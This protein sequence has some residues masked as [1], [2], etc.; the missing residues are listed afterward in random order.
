MMDLAAA[1]HNLTGPI[2]TAAVALMA[3]I[4]RETGV[5]E[6]TAIMMSLEDQPGHEIV[7]HHMAFRPALRR[8]QM[9]FLHESARQTD[10]GTE[11]AIAIEA[12][13]L[14]PV[15]VVVGTGAVA[16][17]I[18]IGILTALPATN[19]DEMMIAIDT[20]TVV[21]VIGVQATMTAAVA[22][23][24]AVLHAEGMAIMTGRSNGRVTMS[25]GCGLYH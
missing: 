9:V 3:V 23:V 20:G 21:T 2:T 22:G 10:T 25:Q 6:T 8:R 16:I 11:T 14:G 15:K 12:H 18:G 24:A 13:A 17:E 7:H 1:T 19:T 4:L 5:H